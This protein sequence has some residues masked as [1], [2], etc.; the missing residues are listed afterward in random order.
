MGPTSSVF[1]WL[2]YAVMFFIICPLFSG[3][4]WGSDTCNK[5]Q[6]IALFQTGWFIESLWSQSLVIHMIRTNKI[7]LFQSRASW[8]LN[9]ATFLVL[10]S[11]D[12]LTLHPGVS[13]SFGFVAMPWPYFLVLA[14]RDLALHAACDFRQRSLPPPLS[15][16]ALICPFH[17]CSRSRLGLLGLFAGLIGAAVVVFL[18][19]LFILSR[20]KKS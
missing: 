10:S 20:T 18:V 12:G 15:G 14:Q 16:G 13:T 8:Q 9:L 7:P 6:F 3:G 5:V 2:T 4:N 19:V 1:D 17:E 11:R